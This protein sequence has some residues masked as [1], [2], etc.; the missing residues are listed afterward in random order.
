MNLYSVNLIKYSCTYYC[1][2]C[3][4]W[5]KLASALN[6]FSAYSHKAMEYKEETFK[7][8]IQLLWQPYQKAALCNS[9]ISGPVR[10]VPLDYWFP[11]FLKDGELIQDF[12]LSH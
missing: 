2:E 8:P 9:T 12:T 3:F 6:M 1:S 5:W 7:H 10:F 11:F 4:K